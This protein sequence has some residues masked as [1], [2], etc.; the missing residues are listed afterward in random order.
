MLAG[1]IQY[2]KAKLGV[3]RRA[4]LSL[5]PLAI[6][7]TSACANDEAEDPLKALYDVKWGDP[8]YRYEPSFPRS[9]IYVKLNDKCVLSYRKTYNALNA[10]IGA[11]TNLRPQGPIVEPG[12]ASALNRTSKM[13]GPEGFLVGQR[14]HVGSWKCWLES[15]KK[16]AQESLNTWPDKIHVYINNTPLSRRVQL[17]IAKEHI[18]IKLNL[19]RIRNDRCQLNIKLLNGK[20]DLVRV[21]ILAYIKTLD[22]IDFQ[23]H[24]YILDCFSRSILAAHGYFGALTIDPNNILRE[25]DIMQKNEYFSF[26]FKSF[27]I[28]NQRREY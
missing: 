7:A 16:V 4:I 3:I 14:I 5:C 23:R 22:E 12:L 1:G 25:Q 9:G 24:F 13:R 26:L 20:I 19:N 27:A 8:K 10:I 18:Q 15:D 2:R 11:S 17:P 28:Q 6:M 21:D